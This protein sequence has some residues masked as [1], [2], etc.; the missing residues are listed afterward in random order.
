[1]YTSRIVGV[2]VYHQ[3]PLVSFTLASKSIPY[4][5]L[6]AN[7]KK[8]KINVFP[9]K[10]YE[11]H[12]TNQD[13]E[14]DNYSCIRSGKVEDLGSIYMVT[15]NGHMC[16]RTAKNIQ[17][18][19][20][21]EIALDLT[22]LEFRGLPNDARIGGVSSLDREGNINLYLGTNDIEKKEKRICAYPNKRR[23]NL[24]DRLFFIYDKDT[25]LEKEFKLNTSVDD[26]ENIAEYIHK[27]I[28]GEEMLFGIGTGV[29][30][31]DEGEFRLGV[32]NAEV[33]EDIVEQGMGKY[34]N[35][36]NSSN[37]PSR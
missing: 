31:F 28:I 10:G 18:N 33:N 20:R 37:R 27:N 26:P 11:S 12:S 6:R 13:P 23:E 25:D 2:G 21:P 8:G 1:M 14:V 19:M 3:K 7:A 34:K 32:Y 15:F 16:K 29:A 5:E 36:N 9:R 4:R 24:E 30:L 22:L 35:V 17:D